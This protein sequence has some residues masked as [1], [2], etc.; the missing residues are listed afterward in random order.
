MDSVE[1]LKG[2]FT[3]GIGAQLGSLRFSQIMNLLPIYAQRG[4]MAT[5]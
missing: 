2:N 4:V 5:C 3:I 1:E